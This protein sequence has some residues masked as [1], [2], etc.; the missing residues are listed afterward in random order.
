MRRLARVLGLALLATLVTAGVMRMKAQSRIEAADR[1]A[2]AARTRIAQLGAIKLKVD[3]Y[4]A[5]KEDASSRRAL[6]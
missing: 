4:E 3:T 2:L 5:W 6:I 1:R